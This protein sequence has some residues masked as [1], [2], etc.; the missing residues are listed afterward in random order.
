M[1]RTF[2]GFMESK[3][4]VMHKMTLDGAPMKSLL[5]GQG[6]EQ[7]LP[8]CDDPVHGSGPGEIVFRHMSVV[9]PGWLRMRLVR[10]SAGRA[11]RG[12]RERS[13]DWDQRPAPRSLVHAFF[14]LSSGGW[15]SGGETLTTAF[16]RRVARDCDANVD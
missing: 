1:F 7:V 10:G 13:L 16:L 14:R 11:D 4:Q 5:P 12:D 9:Q 6:T 8:T 3:I 2:I 15:W